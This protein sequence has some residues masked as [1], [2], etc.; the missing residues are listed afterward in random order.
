MSKA[1]TKEDVDPPE[2]TGRARS[3]SGL[4]PGATNY[5]TAA[6]ARRLR[7]RCEEHRQAGARERAEELEQVLREVTV[8]EPPEQPDRSVGFGARVHV[9]A[10]DGRAAVYQIVGVEELDQ[11]EALSWLSPDGRTLLAA[12]EGDR[13]T[14]ESLGPATIERVEYPAAQP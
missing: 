3:A 7:R 8:V 14:L 5:I 13:V 10:K 1:F 6:G 12:G 9:R 11:P 2:R 4:P